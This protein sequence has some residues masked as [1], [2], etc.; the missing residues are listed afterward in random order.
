MTDLTRVGARGKLKPLP[1][2]R[3]HFQRLRQGVFLGYR[4]PVSGEGPGTWIARARDDLAGKYRDKSL[5]EYGAL[6]GSE[7]FAAAKRDAEAFAV[8]VET[9]GLPDLKLET[10]ADACRAYEPKGNDRATLNRLVFND[11]IGRVR[12]DKLRRHHLR[13]WR[14]RLTGKP[15]TINRAMV[16][17]RAALGAVKEPGRPG[18]DAAWQEALKPVPRAAVRP[19]ERKRPYLPVNDRRTLA[20]LTP[21]VKALTL[22]P[23]RPG[24][25]ASLLVK[26][27]DKRTGALIIRKDKAG[28]GRVIPLSGPARDF[29]AAQCK[30]KTPAAWIFTQA[31]GRQWERHDWANLLRDHGVEAYDIRHAVLTDLADAG[32]PPNALAKLAGTSVAMLEATYY[33]L[34]S[35]AAADALARLAV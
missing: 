28:A 4:P 34:T 35:Q 14:S 25:L 16:P 29:I 24:A 21:L 31:D 10:V 8:E 11:P 30:G 22:L 26:D 3:P 5:G 7:M 17:L 1:G 32:V 6:A 18:T 27:F 23:I 15:S 19:E 2:K 9:G 33:K 20:K 12:L 13:D